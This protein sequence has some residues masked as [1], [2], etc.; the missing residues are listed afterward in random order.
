[1]A[2]SARFRRA[3]SRGMNCGG[4]TEK[5]VVYYSPLLYCPLDSAR[6]AVG[7]L[8]GLLNSVY[9]G[10]N[11]DMKSLMQLNMVGA[12]SSRAAPGRSGPSLR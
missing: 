8:R 6:H 7:R 11:I 12:R 2:P 1:M 5:Q 9:A 3:H 10:K 4:N